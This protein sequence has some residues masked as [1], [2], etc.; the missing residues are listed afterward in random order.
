MLGT[1]RGLPKLSAL[2]LALPTSPS[3]RSS[4][5]DVPVPSHHLSPQ[6]RTMMLVYISMYQEV[7]VRLDG[8]DPLN[9]ASSTH[10]PQI[11]YVKKW[12]ERGVS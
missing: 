11:L 2:S 7:I 8:S 9:S 5:K 1:A 10:Y 3:G 4:W 6:E 12:R